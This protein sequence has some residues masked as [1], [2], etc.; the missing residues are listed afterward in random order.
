VQ[1]AF[2]K[3]R[4]KMESPAVERYFVERQ[5]QRAETPPKKVTSV[6]NVIAFVKTNEGAIGYIPAD[7][8]LPAG[9]KIVLRYP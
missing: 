4:L 5:Y 2:Y 7:T 6:A 3:N 9:V 1:R 8:K